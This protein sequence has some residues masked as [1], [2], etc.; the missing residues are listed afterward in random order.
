MNPHGGIVLLAGLLLT[1]APGDDAVKKELARLQGK[2][3]TVSVEIDG[4]RLEKDFSEDRLIMKA[5]TFLLRA[6]MDSMQ[7]VFTIDPTR[8]PKTIDEEVTAGAHKGTKVAG[9][10]EL[11]GDTLKVCYAHGKKERPKEF[12]TAPGSGLALVIY[13]RIK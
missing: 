7:G 3:Q 2:W 12:K 1:S 11:D 8:T 6:G 13:K 10:Y 9:I 4:R 5:N